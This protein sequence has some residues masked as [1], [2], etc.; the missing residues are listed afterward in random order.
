[1]FGLM[2]NLTKALGRD[3]TLAIFDSYD[4]IWIAVTGRV[5]LTVC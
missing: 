4:Y 3:D 5:F 1:M 2:V